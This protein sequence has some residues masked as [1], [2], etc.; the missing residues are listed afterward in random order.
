M[1]LVS[2]C[3]EESAIVASEVMCEREEVI[4]MVDDLL[5]TVAA[6]CKELIEFEPEEFFC[7]V[8]IASLVEESVL[9]QLETEL[10]VNEHTLRHLLPPPQI[11]LSNHDPIDHVHQRALGG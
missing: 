6:W 11:V 4:D 3:G 5:E 10:L 1:E 7:E 8:V 9:E 2:G